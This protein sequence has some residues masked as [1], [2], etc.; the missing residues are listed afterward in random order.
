VKI[1]PVGNELIHVD[2]RTDG[3]RY[4]R[5]KVS[6]RFS[7]F[8]KVPINICLKRDMIEHTYWSLWLINLRNRNPFLLLS[9]IQK[10]HVKYSMFLLFQTLRYFIRF[11]TE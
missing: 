5:D 10:A 11:C 1:R 6:S 7:K 8:A 3:R 2:R 4:T 9:H